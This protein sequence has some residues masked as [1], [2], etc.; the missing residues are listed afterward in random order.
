[1]VQFPSLIRC[2]RMT[3]Y[4][5]YLVMAEHIIFTKGSLVN[6]KNGCNITFLKESMEVS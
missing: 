6:Q 5:Y 4:V 1:M 3:R 2:F